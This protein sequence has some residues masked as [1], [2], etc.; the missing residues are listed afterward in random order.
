[1]MD[2]APA[3]ML[4]V[5]VFASLVLTLIGPLGHRTA[6]GLLIGSIAVSLAAA[7]ATL[8][9]VVKTGQAVHYHMGDWMPPMGIELV[10]DHLSAGVLVMIS[11]CALLTAIYSMHTAR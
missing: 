6:Y 9:Q 11:F 2:Q 1:M 3:F 8:F 7:L 5:P 4:V 10:I